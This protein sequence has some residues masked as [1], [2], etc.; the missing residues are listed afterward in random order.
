MANKKEHIPGR[1]GALPTRGRRPGETG[2]LGPGLGRGRLRGTGS[3]SLDYHFR[4][5]T[6]S[7]PLAVSG[8]MICNLSNGPLFALGSSPLS[9]HEGRGE[10]Y[11]YLLKSHFAAAA[12][13]SLCALSKRRRYRPRG[14]VRGKPK[15]STSLTEAKLNSPACEDSTSPH[16]H[17]CSAPRQSVF[18]LACPSELPQALPRAGKEEG[19]EE[20][21]TKGSGKNGQ[22]EPVG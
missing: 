16:K 2:L 19:R 1:R 9:L 21:G 4:G 11:C 7:L 8:Q 15:I 13:L 3:G 12:F 18:L 10:E 5:L 22:R 6:A 17:I 14:Q 20:K